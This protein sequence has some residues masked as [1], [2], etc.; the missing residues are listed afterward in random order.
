MPNFTLAVV[1]MRWSKPGPVHR[2]SSWY[3]DFFCDPNRPGVANFWREQSQGQLLL[4]GDVIDWLDLKATVDQLRHDKYDVLDRT[5]MANLAVRQAQLSGA[6]MRGRDGYIVI[7]DVVPPKPT[8][9]DGGATG[10]S[11]ALPDGTSIMGPAALLPIDSDFEFT[12]HETGHMLGINHSFGFPQL[13]D[14]KP[15]EYAH[16]WCIMSAEIYGGAQPVFDTTVGAMDRELVNKGPG[17]N[18]S[19]RIDKG[20]ADPLQVDLEPG[21]DSAFAITSLGS[22]GAGQRYNAIELRVSPAETY[23]VEL[24]SPVDPYDNGVLCPMIVINGGRGSA[25]DSYYPGEYCASYLG[26]IHKPVGGTFSGPGFEVELVSISDDDRR[27][28]V[29]IRENPHAVYIPAFLPRD[30][31]PV[32][33]I[34][35]DGTLNWYLHNGRDNARADWLGARP[36]GYGWDEFTRVFPSEGGVIYAVKADGSLVWYRHDGRENGTFAW[37][38][39]LTVLGD[40]NRFS[41]SFAGAGHALYAVD[42]RGDLRWYGHE[43]HDDGT[44][45]WSGPVTVDSRWDQFT[46]VFPGRDSVIYAIKP[47]GTLLWYRHDGFADGSA[48]WTGPAVVGRGWDQFTRVFAGAAGVVYAAQPDGTLLWFRHDGRRTGA[49]AW[50]GPR[51]V[52]HGWESFIGGFEGR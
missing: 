27:G 49:F 8:G 21:L 41:T 17:L 2:P 5:K 11:A 7:A 4:T 31:N 9:I 45:A 18:S 39:P 46:S 37:A 24:R 14:G 35:S 1:L 30:H 34:G 25:A 52:G 33:G 51:P 50:T 29:T 23:T 16:F 12:A 19:S 13:G 26:E 32:Y 40:W 36:V 44:Y 48:T 10:V 6:N 3:R 20:W 38:G 47:D 43:G 42:S 15:G 28:I 22:S